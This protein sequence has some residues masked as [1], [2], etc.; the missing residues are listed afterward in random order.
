MQQVLLW[1][2]PMAVSQHHHSRSGGHLFCC[3]GW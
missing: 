3:P 1:S 2:G